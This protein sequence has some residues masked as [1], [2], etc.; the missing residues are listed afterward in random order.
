M[1]GHNTA[2]RS[3]IR[4]SVAHIDISSNTHNLVQLIN[5]N[6][7]TFFVIIVF[8]FAKVYFNLFGRV[9]TGILHRWMT[10][11]PLFDPLDFCCQVPKQYLT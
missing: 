2:K 4:V 9:Q 10:G 11:H 6:T 1:E 7:F 8:F 5:K 3:D